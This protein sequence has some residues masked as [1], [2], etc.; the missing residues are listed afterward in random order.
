MKC[1]LILA[2]ALLLTSM[3][4]L[5]AQLIVDPRER[6]RL[7][8]DLYRAINNS[9]LREQSQ[10]LPSPFMARSRAVAEPQVA[11]AA[12]DGPEAASAPVPQALPDAVALQVIARQFRP[13]GS[14]VR[15]DRGVLQFRGGGTL[16]KGESFRATI[17]GISYTVSLEDVSASGYVLRLGEALLQRDFSSTQ[18]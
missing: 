16:A 18:P 8:E 15:G 13:I 3:G 1:R 6:E 7:V 9:A 11:E 2:F 17:D 12:A 10:P 5:S 4:S 14:L